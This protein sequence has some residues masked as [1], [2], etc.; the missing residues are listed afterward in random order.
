MPSTVSHVREG[1]PRGGRGCVPSAWTAPV[2]LL[3]LLLLLF[4]VQASYAGSK[5]AA[6]WH[7]RRGVLNPPSRR[8][9]SSLPN[10]F[11]HRP[12][13]F[14]RRRRRGHAAFPLLVVAAVVLNVPILRLRENGRPSFG[15]GE[16]RWLGL[17]FGLSRPPLRAAR[18]AG[19]RHLK[20]RGSGREVEQDEDGLPGPLC[21]VHLAPPVPTRT[22]PLD[23]GPPVPE[24]A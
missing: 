13:P 9:G 4:L 17:R 3:D 7:G 16:H 15:F 2:D 23:A 18:R 20:G 24:R 11:K 6:P 5:L 8:L 19:V 1:I 10:L 21:P 14:P 22:D 12:W